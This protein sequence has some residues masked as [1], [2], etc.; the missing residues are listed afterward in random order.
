ME[1]VTDNTVN[2]E[3]CFSRFSRSRLDAVK[4]RLLCAEYS[5]SRLTNTW[6]RWHMSDTIKGL[7]PR[8]LPRDA[9]ME[10]GFQDVPA[11]NFHPVLGLISRLRFA[12]VLSL[13]PK[14]PFARL[15]EIGYGSGIFQP[16]L[17]Q[18]CRL[19]YGLDI[20]HSGPAVMRHLR[21]H[22]IDS[23]LTQGSGI[24]LPYKTETFDCIVALSCIE[25][26][27]PLDHAAREIRRILKP[28][29]SFVFITPGNSPLIDAAHD[30]L[31]GRKVQEGY[32]DRR[33]FLVPTFRKYFTFEEQLNAP[34]FGGSW[35]TL[36]RG[37]R[38]SGS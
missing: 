10:T 13:L 8:L 20:H 37:F 5:I 6:R 22:E 35:L 3:T 7:R 29:G 17:A 24:A 27:D 25:Y 23:R 4:A 19:L 32:G 38:L 14:Q 18:H 16:E 31:T 21:E 28:H 34:R 1:S 9:T 30:L 12:L 26:M 2:R 33:A 11:L 15:L 36:Y